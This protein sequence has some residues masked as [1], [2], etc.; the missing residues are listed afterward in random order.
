VLCTGAK[1]A[2]PV[3]W[4]VKGLVVQLYLEVFVAEQGSFN[5][6][7]T[8]GR[9]L[10]YSCGFSWRISGSLTSVDFVQVYLL[11]YAL[12]CV[13]ARRWRFGVRVLKHALRLGAG[14]PTQRFLLG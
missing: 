4:A 14:L 1:I 3:V 6:G 9:I 5:I 12:W 7:V 10:C 13:K 2:L 11:C 8:V